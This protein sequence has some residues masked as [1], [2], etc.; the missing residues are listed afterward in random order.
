MPTFYRT[1]CTG[2]V[3]DL[4][5]TVAVLLDATIETLGGGCVSVEPADLVVGDG[6][7]AVGVSS[8]RHLELAVAGRHLDH[9]KVVDK[10]VAAGVVCKVDDALDAVELLEAK[11]G[12]QPSAVL[13]PIG[14]RLQMVVDV[15]EKDAGA[16]LDAWVARVGRAE[17][18]AGAP[19]RGDADVGA[20]AL[21]RH[22]A[23]EEAATA[24]AAG[25]RVG[26][27]A[28]QREHLPQRLV[29]VERRGEPAPVRPQRRVRFRPLH[30]EPVGQPEVEERQPL[31]VPAD[32]RVPDRA[33]AHPVVAQQNDH[34]VVQH[35]LAFQSLQLLQQ[36]TVHRRQAVGV[37]VAHADGPEEAKVRQAEERAS[38]LHAVVEDSV[39]AGLRPGAVL[40]PESA[41]KI[42]LEEK[43]KDLRDCVSSISGYLHEICIGAP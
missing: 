14:G 9:V 18:G 6:V 15:L 23:G 12:A 13:V 16:V 2:D 30:P 36:T 31:L 42:E 8:H 20:A 40:E 24:G 4:L 35:P 37:L 33:P 43:G 3:L 32:E 28:G 19:V 17:G 7:G 34:R 11:L 21:Q 27:A 38:K 39:E 22:R 41:E 10:V 29:E 25:R 26:Q 1:R 5:E